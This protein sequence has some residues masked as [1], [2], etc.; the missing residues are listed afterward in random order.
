MKITRRLESTVPLVALLLAG[1]GQRS[2]VLGPGT[3]DSS[4][5]E[6]TAAEEARRHPELVDDG[7]YEIQAQAQ[8][9]VSGTTAAIDPL[10]F[11][12]EI[13][14]IE[15]SY[16]FAFADTDSTGQP[17]TAVVTVHKRLGGWFN[18]LA[19]DGTGEG[20]PTE[21]HV[22]RKPLRDHWVRR[23]LLKRVASGEGLER[24][25]WRI[26]AVS[27]VDIT[28]RDAQ[29]R[30]LSLRI[31]S[32]DLDTTVTNPLAF[33]RLRRLIRL[34][35]EAQVQITAVTEAHDDVV[36]LYARNRRMRFHN[37]GDGTHTITWT[38]A[39]LTGLHHVGVNALSHGTLYDDEAAYD[40]RTWILPYLTA[41]TEMAEL[42]P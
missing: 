24:R 28:S 7:L 39:A 4:V 13:L 3:S 8:T 11:W 22:V 41:P 33:W 18:V 36:V 20:G 38:A 6:A 26:A 1:C 10:F 35:P 25:P 19:K 23:V 30:L 17:A 42:A 40:S 2:Q 16:E 9:E 29:T 32:G 5:Q 31:Q 14:R 21:G 12:R 27:S 15:R 37:N 34:E